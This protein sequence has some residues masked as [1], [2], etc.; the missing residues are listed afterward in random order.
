LEI[1]PM[2]QRRLLFLFA[3]VLLLAAAFP[4]VTA[5]SD[6]TNLPTSHFVFGV[7]TAWE[8]TYIPGYT[9]T[10]DN[11]A[12]NLTSFLTNSFF[13]VLTANN[14]FN[15]VWT[16]DGPESVSAEV[17]EFA[18]AAQQFGVMAINGS[19]GDLY[20]NAS[21]NSNSFITSAL[22]NMEAIWNGA[23]PK[24]F[25][26]SLSDEPPAADAKQLA[27][28][29]NQAQALHLPVTTVLA[30]GTASTIL[31]SVQTLPWISFDRYPFF[32]D[33]NSGP[34]GNNSYAYFLAMAPDIGTAYKSGNPQVWA[35][36][37][38][39]QGVEGK[40]AINSDGTVTVA[41]GSGLEWVMP[42]PAQVSWEAWAAAAMGAK[43]I[44]FFSYSQI[45]DWVGTVANPPPKG[46]SWAHK[47]TFNTGSYPALVSFPD[48]T[49]GPQLLQ[50][51]NNTIPDIRSIE[52]ILLASHTLISTP[53][54]PTPVTQASS[55]MAGD[56]INF[57][58]GPSGAIYVAI[59]SSP[60]RTTGSVTLSLNKNI[61]S[62]VPMGNAPA[63]NV[64]GRN[65]TLTLPPGGGAVYQVIEQGA[66]N[67]GGS[68]TGG[69]S[70]PT[71][72]GS[73]SGGGSG[74]R[75]GGSSSNGRLGVTFGQ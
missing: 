15:L 62:L 5:S 11:R 69:G 37:Q 13:P 70:G 33:P 39:F 45:S 30:P 18:A 16:T 43:G 7:Y 27:S 53:P 67:S 22:T 46:A 75:S 66:T 51:Q 8:T 44:I 36:G 73:S 50:L 32:G 14:S 38:S 12:Q 47:T 60:Q 31:A 35:M 68:T 64:S 74:P 19:D 1:D 10:A 56:Y 21:Q 52:N 72:G 71:G 9:D 24:P 54:T 42:T 29:V 26:F 20:L 57:L 65:A 17:S 63:L 58:G 6:T 25:A 41:A 61:Q 55:H 4:T 3:A 34:T 40:Y 48:Y 2:G 28:Y 59:V 49:P 23:N